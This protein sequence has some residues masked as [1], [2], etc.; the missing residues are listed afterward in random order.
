MCLVTVVTISLFAFVLSDLDRPFHGFFKVS[1]HRLA[2]AFALL[3]EA[4][5]TLVAPEDS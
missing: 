1:L 3:D 4:Y 5:K 2:E